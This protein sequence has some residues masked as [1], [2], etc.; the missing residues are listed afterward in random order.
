MSIRFR[1]DPELRILFTT[2]EGTLTFDEIQQHLRDESAHRALGHRELFDASHARLE[3]NSEEIR[4][5]V[6]KLH[7]RLLEGPFGPTA[8]VTVSDYFF[9]MASMLA[10]LTELRGGPKIAVFRR[11][12]EALEW[13]LRM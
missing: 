1:F 2:A 9:G 13:L 4:A 6:S 5:L 12:N 3:M 11:I 10:I 7:K 8:L